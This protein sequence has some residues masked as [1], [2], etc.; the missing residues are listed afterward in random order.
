MTE[1]DILG[2]TWIERLVELLAVD[3]LYCNRSMMSTNPAKPMPGSTHT[4]NISLNSNCFSNQTL[5]TTVR[6]LILILTL[7]SLRSSLP[8]LLFSVQYQHKTSKCNFE[9]PP[10][11]LL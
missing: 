6:H 1:N 8:H 7:T 9:I 11:S 10:P 5:I 3:D 4:M 2:E